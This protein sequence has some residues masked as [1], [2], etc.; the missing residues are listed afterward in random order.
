MMKKLLALLLCL[1]LWS[2]PTAMAANWWDS[3]VDAAADYL[4]VDKDELHE[5]VDGVVDAAGAVITT[6]FTRNAVALN[7]AAQS[8]YL[9][10]C[11][12][13]QGNEFACGSAFHC[14]ANGVVV[15]NYHVVEGCTSV[16][17]ESDSGVMYT[18]A[19]MIAANKQQD[20][21]LLYVAGGLPS[22]VLKYKSSGLLR[23]VSCA[24]IGSGLG[25]KNT[26]TKGS[27]TNLV[28]SKG[29]YYVQ[30]GAAINHGNS[31]GPLF[32]DNG[33]VI[34][35]NTLHLDEGDGLTQSVNWAVRMDQAEALYTGWDGRSLYALPGK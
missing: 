26:I 33:Y 18:T 29:V 10:H 35:I 4:E 2:V 7:N 31:G 25:I 5:A 27:V 30:H 11:L 16:V 6:G 20:I 28:E 21:A 8:V 24:A 13:A 15:T 3:L 23:G 34:G 9:V 32:D 22:T 12:D 19:R 17:L 1:C 14:F